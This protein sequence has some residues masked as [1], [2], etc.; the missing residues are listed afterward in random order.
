MT[1]IS[2]KKK[3]RK[4]R[5]RSRKHMENKSNL[6]LPIIALKVKGQYST[7]KSQRLLELIKSKP[8]PNYF[9]ST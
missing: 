1:E 6:I 4:R 8:K 3:E 2:Y 7:I 5:M 9:I